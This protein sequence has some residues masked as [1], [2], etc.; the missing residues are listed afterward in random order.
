MRKINTLLLSFCIFAMSSFTSIASDGKV[1]AEDA[2]SDFK[3]ALRYMWEGSYTQFTLKQN[4]IWLGVSA[5]FLYY[6]FDQDDHVASRY[7][8]HQKD[9]YDRLLEAIS[10]ASAFPLFHVGSYLVG[11]KRGDDKLV[12]FSIE[13][14]STTYLVMI[15]SGLLSHIQ[16]HRRPDESNIN[17][18]EKR[19]RGDSSFPS[20]HIV[21]MMA[22]TIKS[23]QYYGPMAS[24]APAV[25][26]FLLAQE[27]LRNRK[28]HLSDVVGAVFLTIFASEGVRVA[29]QKNYQSS[30]HEWLFGKKGQLNFHYSYDV[31]Q[32]SYTLKF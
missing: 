9:D 23:L 28:H 1:E 11:K 6:S 31:K 14:F 16:I 8:N 18:W 4:A 27:R 20:G 15:E 26:T 12:S 3:T 30:W 29:S 13:L 7:K 17:F 22:L 21:P 25:L 24:L 19:F 2:W 10:I 32:L 5:P